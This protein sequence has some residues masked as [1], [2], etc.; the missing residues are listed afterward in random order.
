VFGPGEHVTRFGQFTY[1]CAAEIATPI[2]P[3]DDPAIRFS[4]LWSDRSTVGNDNPKFLND[5]GD[6]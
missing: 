5:P 3:G 6:F 1:R 2:D 4:I